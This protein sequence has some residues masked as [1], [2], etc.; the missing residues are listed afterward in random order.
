MYRQIGER[1]MIT[2]FTLDFWSSKR[3]DALFTLTNCDKNEP[4]L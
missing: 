3:S 2:G 1:E 4:E